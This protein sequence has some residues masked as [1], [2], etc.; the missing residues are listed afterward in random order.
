MT[1]I[2]LKFTFKEETKGAVRYQEV[3]DQ[4]TP[5]KGDNDEAVVGPLYLRK[6]ALKRLNGGAYPPTLIARLTI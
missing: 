1:E 3:D 5:R 4:G 6:A 2:T